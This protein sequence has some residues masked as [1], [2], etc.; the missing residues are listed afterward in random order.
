MDDRPRIDSLIKQFVEALNNDNFS[1]IPLTQEVTYNGSM[2][3]DALVGAAQVVE[4]LQQISPFLVDVNI[5]EK[6]IEADR[7]AVIVRFTA[8]N[9]IQVLCCYFLRFQ[10]GKICEIHAIFDSHFLISG[11]QP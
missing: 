8:V 1:A 10:L 3:P 7:A 5:K 2:L 9:G 4:H 6:V 11:T